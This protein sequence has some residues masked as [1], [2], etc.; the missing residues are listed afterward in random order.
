[1]WTERERERETRTQ[2]LLLESEKMTLLHCRYFQ[3]IHSA[4]ARAHTH[5]HTPRARA[6]TH[7]HTHTHTYIYIRLTE[8][9]EEEGV[10]GGERECKSLVVDFA[11]LLL[12]FLCVA[13]N[14]FLF[15][16]CGGSCVWQ[17][18]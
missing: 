17:F 9:E 7:T 14:E 6:H 2:A 4:R 10:G 18:M 12:R 13:V 8:E 1:M 15:D 3:A 16:V 5:K 11:P